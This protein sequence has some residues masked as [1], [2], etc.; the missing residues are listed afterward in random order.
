MDEKVKWVTIAFIVVLYLS[1]IPNGFVWLDHGDIEL[2]RSIV[3]TLGLDQIF[4]SRF[5]ATGFYRPLVTIINSLDYKIYN[6][7]PPGY[8]LTSILIHLLAVLTVPT[9]LSV[10][11]NFNSREKLIIFSTAAF[12]PLNWLVIGAISYRSEILYVLFSM[13][14]VIFFSRFK[15]N[16]NRRGICFVFFLI[17]YLL[18]IFS[19]ETA[20]VILP[21]LLFIA[22]NYSSKQVKYQFR[23]LL[24]L[25]ITILIVSILYFIL[26]H[27]AVPEFWRSG[28][29]E[30]SFGEAWGTRWKAAG[31][32][33]L[34][35]ISPVRPSISDAIKV[36]QWSHIWSL[37]AF[38]CTIGSIIYVYIRR[39]VE[40]GVFIAFILFGV[41]FLPV[42]QIVPAPRFLSLHYGYFSALIIGGLLVEIYRT[43]ISGIRN[44]RLLSVIV[45]LVWIAVSAASIFNGGRRFFNDRELFLS[46]VEKQPEFREGNQYL[47][48]YYFY[49]REGYSKSDEEFENRMERA[50]RYYLAALRE[51]PH[52]LAYVDTY[53]VRINLSG[54]LLRLGELPLAEREL[55]K[56]IDLGYSSEELDYNLAVIL[57]QREKYDDVINVIE[58]RKT[59]KIKEAKLLLAKAYLAKGNKEKAEK[60]LFVK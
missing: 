60:I 41:T 32:I 15:L 2:Q 12:H 4:T 56:L 14:S 5:A 23:Y 6:F 10:F 48:D 44:L 27:I 3:P 25:F 36:V 22:N 20:V 13:W 18:A 39:K 9:F 16:T 55:R 28:Y 53:S 19:K 51:S 26:R 30:L 17:C 35:L 54:A 8:H 34:Y 42:F 47:G 50:K 49:E 58:K 1:Y 29:W 31:T 52:H 21:L 57:F 24:Y 11:L 38:F 43:K 37:V 40:R 33:L 46:E 7:W 59:W 45:F